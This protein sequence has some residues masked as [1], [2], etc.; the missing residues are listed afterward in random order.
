MQ[1]DELAEHIRDRVEFWGYD[2]QEGLTG[3]IGIQDKGEV[4]LIRHAYV[5]T[6]KRNGGIGTKVVKFFMFRL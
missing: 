5:V 2:D 4:M 1:E 3:V 6:S